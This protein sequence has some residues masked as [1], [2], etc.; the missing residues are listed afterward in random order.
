MDSDADIT[1]AVNVA[2]DPVTAFEGFVEELV[3]SWTRSAAILRDRRAVRFE[4]GPGGR[5]LEH[6]DGPAG[7]IVELGRVRVWEPGRRFVFE[8]NHVDW[9]PHQV[10]KVDVRF[11]A[12]DG[13]ARVTLALRGWGRLLEDAGSRQERDLLGWFVDQMAAPMIRAGSPPVIADWVIDRFARRPAGPTA[14]ATYRAP[15]EHLPA[16]QAVL[17]A[18][19]PGPADHLLEIGCG[20]GILLQQALARGCRATGVDHSEE[21]VQLALEQN[22][23]AVAE[24]RLRVVQA[25]AEQLPFEDGGFT[26]VAMAMMFFFLPD[27]I[28]VLAECRRVLAV[29]GR[30]AIATVPSEL[31]GT[32]AA[33]EPHA[34][35]SHFY[36][37]REL[38]ALARDAG[39]EGAVASRTHGGQLLTAHRA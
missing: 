13:G 29:G 23:Q 35:Q 28:A 30:L 24:G 7:S 4:P 22:E 8:W 15:R 26:C 31:R 9:A 20:G 14:R 12:R 38:E 5:L 36:E 10:A 34:S 3:A 11:A 33:P 6:V 25:E 2:L 39:L 17:T 18:L 1:V 37:D 32:P 21:M 27:P 19:D 16:F